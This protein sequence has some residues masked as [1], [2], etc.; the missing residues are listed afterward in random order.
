MADNR[1]NPF[2]PIGY[3]SSGRPIFP[4]MGASDDDDDDD[5]GGSGTGDGADNGTEGASGEPTEYAPPSEA[6]WKRT[7]E[8]L[9]R[10][11]AEA[12]KHR[13]KV[14]EL[15]K[16]ADGTDDEKTRKAAEDAEKRFKPVAVRS[17]AK[18]A[19][20]EAGLNDATPDRLKKLLR[21]IEMDDVDVDD[22][23]DVSGLDDQVESIKAD[24]PELFKAPERRRAGRLDASN[25]SS[26]GTFAPKTTG[27]KIAARVLS[28]K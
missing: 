17:A 24:Y 23:G 5:S 9:A 4:V 26:D 15:S 12:K 21:L 11:N 1:P 28:G 13:L 16:T 7:Q 20:L 14:R 18:A 19:F 2:E 22:D 3:W 6:E 25:R 10:A 8:A 27:E